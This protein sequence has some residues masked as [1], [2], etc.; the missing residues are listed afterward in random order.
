MEFKDVQYLYRRIFASN[1]VDRTRMANVIGK[2]LKEY[3][4]TLYTKD[5]HTISLDVLEEVLKL[6]E[7]CILGRYPDHIPRIDFP[8][9]QMFKLFYCSQFETLQQFIG[10]VDYTKK[11]Q[12]FE[13]YRQLTGIP[14]PKKT[15][16]D[17]APSEHKDKSDSELNSLRGQIKQSY[18][19]MRVSLIQD[20]L[21][22]DPYMLLIREV[23]KLLE[24]KIKFISKK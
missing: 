6:K 21:L 19:Q 14:V 9:E 22:T 4:R 15:L 7:N 17:Y 18:L 2:A 10:F 11:V 16:Q 1:T 12:G 13:V 20:Y 8:Y 5:T 24:S 23:E 3:Q